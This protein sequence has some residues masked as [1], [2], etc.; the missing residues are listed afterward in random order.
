MS[1]GDNMKKL[2]YV[3]YN[4]G[5]EVKRFDDWHAAQEYV[6]LYDGDHE[7]WYKAEEVEAED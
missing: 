5:L 7:V 4:D 6:N 3:I 2:E 1:K